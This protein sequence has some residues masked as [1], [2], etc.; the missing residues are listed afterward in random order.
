MNTMDT[1]FVMAN[2]R[3]RH[4]LPVAVGARLRATRRSRGMSSDAVARAIDVSAAYVR[5]LEL[6]RRAP[7]VVVA[8]ALIDVLEMPDDVATLLM[9]HAVSDA[10]RSRSL[11]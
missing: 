3:K 7:S 1:A 9:A 5:L 4:R 8:C 11:S 10:G 2:Q 6:G